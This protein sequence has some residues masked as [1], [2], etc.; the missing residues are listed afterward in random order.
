MNSIPRLRAAIRKTVRGAAYPDDTM[1]RALNTFFGDI[2][3]ILTPQ[4]LDMQSDG[5]LEAMYWSWERTALQFPEFEARLRQI[6]LNCKVYLPMALVAD[7]PLEAKGN[8]VINMF[9]LH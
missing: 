3:C 5:S 2:L 7:E 4:F 1:E 8:N 6:M 9:Q